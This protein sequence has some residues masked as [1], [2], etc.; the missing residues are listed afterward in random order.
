MKLKS[1]NIILCTLDVNLHDN[2][3]FLNAYKTKNF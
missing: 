3:R 1:E 2:Y